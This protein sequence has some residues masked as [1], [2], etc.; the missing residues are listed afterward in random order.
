LYSNTRRTGPSS[1]PIWKLEVA[2]EKR[3]RHPNALK[4]HKDA[5]E[6]GPWGSS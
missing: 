1:N 2:E 3:V 5:H 4:R 6:M